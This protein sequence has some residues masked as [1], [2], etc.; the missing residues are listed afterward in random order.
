MGKNVILWGIGNVYN[1]HINTLR[2][3]E[4]KKEIT[5]IGVTALEVPLYR[6]LDGYPIIK[7]ENLKEIDYDYIIIMSDKFFLEIVEIAFSYGVL[8]QQILPYR[9]FEIAGLNFEKYIKVKQSN[10]TIL[11]NNC[12]GGILYYNL[13]LECLSPFK[14]MSLGEESFMKL[15]SNLKYYMEMVPQFQSYNIDPHSHL[16]YP[17]MRLGEKD[18]II[19]HFN[20]DNTKEE[21]LE[22]WNRRKKKINYKN[23]FVVMYTE[24]KRAA[25]QFLEL[26]YKRKICFVP[27]KTTE[28]EWFELSLLEGQKE[29]WEAVNRSASI[30]GIYSLLDL[31]NGEK[32]SRYSDGK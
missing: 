1:Q 15:V 21:A 30:N 7:K 2:Y 11:S 19:L 10:L 4:L 12:F 24:N 8:R 17:V 27:W 32:K 31:V 6:C 20:H 22:K 25:E 14:N 18:E 3:F 13:G 23:I 5:I 16:Q 28:K 29:F 26:P 9:V